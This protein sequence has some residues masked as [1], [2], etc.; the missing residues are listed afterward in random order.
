MTKPPSES[1]LPIFFT[2]Q[3]PFIMTSDQ[4]IFKLFQS[5]YNDPTNKDRYGQTGIFNFREAVLKAGLSKA[6][7]DHL[8]S[9]KSKYGKFS[10]YSNPNFLYRAVNPTC[11]FHED[12]SK[13][14]YAE[15][16]LRLTK[17]SIF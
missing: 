13:V 1:A 3:S 12:L 11:Q 15:D 7:Y 2:I 14:R 4:E 17:T 9:G 16:M 8:N 6:A 10:T 5:I